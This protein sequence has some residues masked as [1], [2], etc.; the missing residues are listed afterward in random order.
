MYILSFIPNGPILF[1]PKIFKD[2][3][4]CFFESFNEKEFNQL[5]GE[6]IKFVQD[7]ES[8]SSYG[9]LRGLHFQK[10]E[11]AQSKLVRVIKGSVID[12]AVDIRPDSDTFGRYFWAHLSEENHRMFFVPKG[13]AHGFLALS[14][15]TIFQYKCDNYYNKESEGSISCMDTE[16]GIPWTTWINIEEAIFSDK[17]L[18]APSFA[19]FK[20]EITTE[21]QSNEG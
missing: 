7:N 1:Q 17:D 9:V 12:V 16:I 2:N 18:E 13:F 8:H 10:G 3:R 15:D 4:G 19:E 21:E 5:I 6:D 11:H 14:N 20:K